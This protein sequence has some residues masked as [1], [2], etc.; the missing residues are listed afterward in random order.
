[1]L[2]ARPPPQ[3]PRAAQTPQASDRPAH[4]PG[5]PGEP[6]KGIRGSPS[7]TRPPLGGLPGSV[8]E[9]APSLCPVPGSPAGTVPEQAAWA[10]RGARGPGPRPGRWSGRDWIGKRCRGR[11]GGW[12]P[13]EGSRWPRPTPPKRAPQASGR[14]GRV[15]PGPRAQE[16]RDV[17]WEGCS[18]GERPWGPAPSL[19]AP[20]LT[21]AGP[22]WR[23]SKGCSHGHPAS[24]RWGP[25]G[26]LVSVFPLLR[27]LLGH[28]CLGH[29][30]GSGGG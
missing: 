28:P 18:G 2:Q 21:Q 16:P 8:P 25:A 7:R 9:P 17:G 19:G 24:G 29:G 6:T 22:P 20:S 10:A 15:R 27:S 30:C 3:P 5:F 13:G 11:G 23:A 4:T 12:R 1:M 26:V 14:C